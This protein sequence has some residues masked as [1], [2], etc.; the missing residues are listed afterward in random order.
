MGDGSGLAQQE[1]ILVALDDNYPPGTQIPIADGVYATIGAGTLTESTPADINRLSSLSMRSRIKPSFLL[2]LG[3][4]V[5][6]M[7]PA[8]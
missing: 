3:Y 6:S 8:P 2:P 1:T 5:Y 4:K 7:A